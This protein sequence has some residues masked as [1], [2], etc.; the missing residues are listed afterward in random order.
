M[1]LQL[2]KWNWMLFILWR[3][4]SLICAIAENGCTLGISLYN[5]VTIFFCKVIEMAAKWSCWWYDVQWDDIDP[6]SCSQLCWITCN[7]LETMFDACGFIILPEKSSQDTLTNVAQG[8]PT[9]NMTEGKPTSFKKRHMFLKLGTGVTQGVSGQYQKSSILEGN[10]LCVVSFMRRF[11][12]LI[13]FHFA[14]Q[15]WRFV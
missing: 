14:I 3:A 5:K 4:L 10:S 11:I 6:N 2:H 15:S 8:L 12:I 7:E 9:C 1:S 13:I